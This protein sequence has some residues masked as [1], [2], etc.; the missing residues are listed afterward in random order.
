MRNRLSL[1][2]ASLVLVAAAYVVG[3]RQSSAQGFR[4][5]VGSIWEGNAT[6]VSGGLLH[7]VQL[8]QQTGTQES[9]S[10]IALPRGGEIADVCARNDGG[11]DASV[12]WLLY[13]DGALFEYTNTAGWRQ[14]GNLAI[15][16]ATTALPQSWGQVK[17]R[18]HK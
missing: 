11:G 2:C 6:Y 1:V 16:G 17:D 9:I 4:S 8:N 14:I 3:S 5:G 15:G 10:T 18:Y 13:A 12:A 7:V